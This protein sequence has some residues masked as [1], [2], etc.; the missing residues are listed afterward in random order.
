MLPK[1]CLLPPDVRMGPRDRI[2]MQP[3]SHRGCQLWAWPEERR[4]IHV[5]RRGQSGHASNFGC[6][7]AIFKTAGRLLVY[8]KMHLMEDAPF[9]PTQFLLHGWSS[10][11]LCFQSSYN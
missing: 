10:W 7:S 1:M 8:G 4:R 11:C 3:S 2:A 5:S 9:S 6:I